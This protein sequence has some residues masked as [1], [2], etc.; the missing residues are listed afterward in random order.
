RSNCTTIPAHISPYSA[1]VP[2]ALT[3]IQGQPAPS[4][5]QPPLHARAPSASIPSS[6]LRNSMPVRSLLHSATPLSPVPPGITSPTCACSSQTDARQFTRWRSHAAPL[7]LRSDH[8]FHKITLIL[9]SH[10]HH[11]D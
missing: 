11:L 3:A 4:P 9:L 7:F 8:S 5:I 10:F 6:L 2:T 1:P